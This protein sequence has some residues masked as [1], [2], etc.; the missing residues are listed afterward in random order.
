MG[1][2]LDANMEDFCRAGHI[3]NLY[4]PIQTHRVIEYAYTWSDLKW[5]Q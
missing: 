4:A 2:N 5:S 3:I 1:Q